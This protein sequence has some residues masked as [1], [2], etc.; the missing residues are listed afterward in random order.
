MKDYR[1]LLNSV[2][3]SLR[4][5]LLAHKFVSCIIL[6][7]IVGVGGGFGAIAF[8]WLINSFHQFFFG[9][10][11]VLLSFLGQYYVIFVPAVGGLIVGCII[12]FTKTGET[13][14][15]GVPE[16]MEAVWREGGRIRPRVAAVK[17]FASSICLGS[18]G[19]AGREGP[20]VQIGSSIG[21]TAA[22]LFR[23]P[24]DLI[25]TLVACGAAAGI[26]ATFN[27]PIGGIFFALE[28]ILG[29]VVS[30][31][32]GFVALSS[33]VAD[34]IAH[35]FL[36]DFR[37]FEVPVQYT[38]NSHGEVPLY[39]LLGVLCA[40]VATLFIRSLYKIEDG[41][42]ALRLPEYLKPA[43]GGIIVG[44]IGFYN[45]YL[46]GVGYDGVQQVLLG[47]VGFVTLAALLFLKILATS[48]T[49]GSGGS[50]GIFAPSLFMGS[51]LGGLFGKIAYRF[52][53]GIVAPSGA[54]ALVGMAGVFAGVAQAPITSFLILFEMTGN[55][56]MILPLLLA[57]VTST[58]L[59]RRLSREN[60]YTL[61]LARRGITMRPMEETEFLRGVTVNE[62]MT[63]NYP[64]VSPQM[65]V[66]ELIKKLNNTGH[67]GL[68]VVD[69]AGHLCGM[70]T[71]SDVESRIAGDIKQLT[72]ADIA[73][74]KL[75]TVYPDQRLSELV[76]HLGM[77]TGEIPRIPVVSR[78]DPTKLI[79]ML[80]RQDI[81]KGYAR[82]VTTIHENEN[83]WY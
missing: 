12:Y 69:Q 62:V 74:T 71:L 35:T 56:G 83:S 55:Y 51:M 16:V 70:V 75:I 1:N 14:G 48:F 64:T 67:H 23:L 53:P 40:L 29:R 65:S 79:G 63:R 41:F 25:K 77:G 20:I 61:K 10:M 57:V 28:V 46:F 17:V 58:L 34:L 68:P 66:T 2:L 32:L 59:A 22:Q 15:H 19:S 24:E 76:D 30:P 50:G 80:R 7:G 36:G 49:L 18:G 37:T 38:L 5:Y 11:G 13:K 72:V 81:I 21:S 78:E 6:S 73:T 33:V 3:I 45:P 4:S 8:R 60:I 31:R 43:L 47:N 27:A 42:D 82:I 39:I 44:L 9:G 26:S 54:Y 52:L